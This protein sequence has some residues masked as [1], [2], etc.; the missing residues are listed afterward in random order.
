MVH[1]WVPLHFDPLRRHFVNIEM[2]QRLD[3]PMRRLL[4]IKAKSLLCHILE[5][6]QFIL[7]YSA[8]FALVK[9]MQEEPAPC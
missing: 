3:T 9:A 7:I 2:A 1:G 6:F 5:H 8:S 4:I